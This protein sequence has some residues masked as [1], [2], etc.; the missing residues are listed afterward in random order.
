MHAMFYAMRQRGASYELI[1]EAFARGISLVARVRGRQVPW[2]SLLSFP[3]QL[4]A[5]RGRHVRR[6]LRHNKP[7][8][9]ANPIERHALAA[10]HRQERFG[11]WETSGRAS[12]SGL[13]TPRLRCIAGFGPH[14]PAYDEWWAWRAA[15]DG[16]RRRQRGRSSARQLRASVSAFCFAANASPNRKILSLSSVRNTS[17]PPLTSANRYKTKS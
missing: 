1:K 10:H 9:I 4:L 3:Q 7:E 6:V 2:S 16:R 11:R 17:W 15:F 14:S 13:A 8:P 5:P 12:W